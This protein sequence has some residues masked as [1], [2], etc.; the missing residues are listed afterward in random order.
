MALIKGNHLPQEK[1][2]GFHSLAYWGNIILIPKHRT[3]RPLWMAAALCINS[4]SH[5]PQGSK[6]FDGSRMQR[7][8]I[9]SLQVSGKKGLE[10]VKREE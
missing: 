7:P 3:Q 5:E 1:Q 2:H 8:T 6:G 10:A 9:S 4:S